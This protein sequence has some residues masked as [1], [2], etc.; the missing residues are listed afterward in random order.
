MD[1]DDKQAAARKKRAE[2]LRSSVAKI[3]TAAK[4]E[5]VPTP[6][7]ITDESARKSCDK[8]NDPPRESWDR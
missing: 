7:E 3:E 8:A 5:G 6:K 2:E 4:P 1:P